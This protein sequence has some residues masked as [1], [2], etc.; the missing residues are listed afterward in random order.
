MVQLRTVSKKNRKS[1]TINSSKVTQASTVVSPTD[2][3]SSKSQ[4]TTQPAIKTA[5]PKPRRLT[6]FKRFLKKRWW[7]ILLVLIVL[8]GGA[9]Y[10]QT[11]QQ[12]QVEPTL[13]NP[14]IQD[15]SQ[16]I[17]VPCVIDAKQKAR[18]RFLSGGKVV[19]L[20]AKE[21]DWVKKY[22]TIA[23]V[24]TK[25]LEKQLQQD[26]NRYMQERWN[27]EQT[28]DDTADRFIDEREQRTV[29]QEQWDLDNQVLNVEIRDIAVRDSAIYSPIAGILTTSPTAVTGV[30]LS[31]T[32]AFE[33]VDPATLICRAAID[34]VDIAPVKIDMPV[35]V[36]LDSF[37]D[38]PFSSQLTFIS[39]IA[40]RSESGTV[41]LV[42]APLSGIEDLNTFR[43]GMNGDAVIEI[44]QKNDVMVIPIDTTRSLDGQTV[45]SVKTGDN[46][47]ED[48]VITT[49]IETDDLIEVTSG[50]T[51]EDQVVVPD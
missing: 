47:F 49:G 41:F 51:V 42:E 44:L 43:I 17:D 31:P 34:E 27:W 2:S 33:I 45:V 25:T 37:P 26:L 16:T 38:Q 10:W 32:D 30:Q 28:L 48:R 3:S 1:T 46:T 20:S 4:A 13:V 19:Y 6:R 23:R 50:L 9:G 24:D 11:Q 15:L 29:D 5:T 21:G 8:G 36:T 22:Q 40:S 39:P 7:V 14:S 18:L 35:T 12:S